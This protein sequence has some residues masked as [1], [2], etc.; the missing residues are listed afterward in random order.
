MILYF[1][2][3]G[4]TRFVAESLSNILDE[5]IGL[6]STSHPN[7]L[8]LDGKYLIFS[9]PVYSWGVPPLVLDYIRELPDEI[10]DWLKDKDVPVVMVCTC[11]DE[12]A[13][14]PEMFRSAWADR[15]IEVKGIWSVIMPNDYVLLPGFDVDAESIEMSKLDAAPARIL[16]IA[17]KIA[18]EAWETDVIR[19]KWPRLKSRLVYPLFKKWGINPRKWSVSEKCVHCGRCVAACPVGNIRM[20]SG[21]PKWGKR[22]VSC[23]ACYHIC[24]AKAISY[25]RVTSG[26]GQYYCHLRPIKNQL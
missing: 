20:S 25:G 24:P 18:T 11:G 3:T 23:T 21:T 5:K 16:E 2:G 4:N 14:T 15:G 10:V 19:G 9:F 7:D 8:Q 6:L 26:K 12:V 13:E 1:S 22:C 17:Q